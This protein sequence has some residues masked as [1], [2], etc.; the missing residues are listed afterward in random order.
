MST[1]SKTN[2]LSREEKINLGREDSG[3]Y[4]RYMAGFVGFTADDAAAIHD[5]G[6]IVEK[7]IPSIVARFYTHLLSY[8]PTRKHF[9]NAEGKVDQDYLQLRM[10]HLTNFWRKTAGGKFDDEYARYVDYVGRAHTSR[11]ADPGIYIAERYVIGQVGFMQH[12][13]TSATSQ[14]LHE[15]DPD[16]EVRALKAWNLL[17]MVI[18]EM[19]SRAYS[20]EHVHE[21]REAPGTVNA[22]AVLDLAVET[23][24]HGLGLQRLG[25]LDEVAICAL[26]EIPDGERKIV[27]IGDLSIGIFHHRGGWYALR[28]SCLHRGGPVCTGSL[29]GDVLTCPWHGFQ[30]NVTNGQFLVD[31]TARLTTYPIEIK[32]GMIYLQVP[33]QRQQ[34]F[35]LT[36]QEVE[37]IQ[38]DRGLKKNEFRLADVAPGEMI[39]VSLADQPVTVFNSNGHYYAAQDS[40]PH[41]G[42]PLH[43][44]VFNGTTVTCP[45]HGSCFDV[46]DGKVK[47]GPADRS[48]KTFQVVIEGDIGMVT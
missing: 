5:S 12:A 22:Q 21:A 6:L 30:Y 4:F 26:D 1:Q 28:N 33:V 48:L 37:I 35:D 8:P 36:I 9:I 45:W 39:L 46:T 38:V 31:P 19:L 34:K 17:M 44:G 11:G 43:E 29:Q 24:E 20:E 7:H 14:E 41:A 42:G 2:I 15:V 27:Q 32:K 10:H 13:I 47:R 16:L 23:Y 18:L 25:E 3:Q 40:C